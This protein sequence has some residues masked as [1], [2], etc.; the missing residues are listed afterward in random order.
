M[1]NLE[2]GEVSTLRS[3]SDR[4]T[5]LTADLR[6][7][8]STEMID[9]KRLT[10]I[11]ALVNEVMNVTNEMRSISDDYWRWLDHAE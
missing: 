5:G 3:C 2:A 8:C 10:G 9:A 11:I 4:L 6:G 7:A 1:S